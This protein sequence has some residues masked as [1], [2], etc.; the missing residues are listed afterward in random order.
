[1]VHP[2]IVGFVSLIIYLIPLKKT[3]DQRVF[4]KF[5]N[6]VFNTHCCQCLGY[7]VYLKNRYSSR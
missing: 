2:I 7:V 4:S 5:Y 1:M 6:H 3:C